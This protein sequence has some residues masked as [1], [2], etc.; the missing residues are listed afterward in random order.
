MQRYIKPKPYS[1]QVIALR[2]QLNK[3]EADLKVHFYDLN[4]ALTVTTTVT[5]SVTLIANKC[6]PSRNPKT[7]S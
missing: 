7:Y 1:G 4:I 2:A 3:K 5:G 6:D